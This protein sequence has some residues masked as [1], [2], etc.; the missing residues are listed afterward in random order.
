M[1]SEVRQRSKDEQPTA[2]A[3]ATQDVDEPK[4]NS[5]RKRTATAKRGLRSLSIAVALPLILSL[6]DIYYFGARD[7]YDRTISSKP[8]TA[9][10]AWLPPLWVLHVSRLSSAAVMGVSGWL[11][12]AQGGFHG[13]RDMLL[14]FLIQFGLGLVWDPIVFKLGSNLAG[15]AVSAAVFGVLLR[16]SKLFGNVSSV[17]GDLVKPCLAWAGLLGFVNLVLLLASVGH[18]DRAG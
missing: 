10:A 16:C 1:A 17:A 7:S 18:P 14:L 3:A 2:A 11:V 15:L 4:K 9:A 5:S 12:W 13:R 8:T 6:A